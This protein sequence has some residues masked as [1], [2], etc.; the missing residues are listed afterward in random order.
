MSLGRTESHTYG[1]HKEAIQNLSHEEKLLVYL[2]ITL[3]NA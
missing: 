1:P 2:L 3:L